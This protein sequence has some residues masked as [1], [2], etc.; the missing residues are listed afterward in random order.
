[1]RGRERGARERKISVTSIKC[2]EWVCCCFPASNIHYRT[3][4]FAFYCLCN[5]SSEIAC[6]KD[7]SPLTKWYMPTVNVQRT[8]VPCWT[9]LSLFLPFFLH[10]PPL[11]SIRSMYTKVISFLPLRIHMSNIP[12]AFFLS[13]KHKSSSLMDCLAFTI[14]LHTESL[15]VFRD[16][17]LFLENKSLINLSTVY[18][19]SE[20]IDKPSF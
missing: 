16:F 7:L 10:S 18:L 1:M 20:L 5:L 11:T 14:L 9:F 6:L 19:L 17:F 12:L 4:S 13:Y 2:E 15:V 3:V 8:S